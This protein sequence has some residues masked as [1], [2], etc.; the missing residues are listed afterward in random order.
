MCNSSGRG[1]RDGPGCDISE[2]R[3]VDTQA[4]KE[5]RQCSEVR[6]PQGAHLRLEEL[7]GQNPQR[8]FQ[9]GATRSM[10]GVQRAWGGGTGD[11]EQARLHQ[12]GCVGCG[13]LGMYR[14]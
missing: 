1:G 3:V 14:E 13:L 12:L 11:R 4:G 10:E 6:E 9:G 5:P 2:K 7:Q 8:A